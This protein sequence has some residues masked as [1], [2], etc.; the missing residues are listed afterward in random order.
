MEI[1]KLPWTK[2]QNPDYT[3][4][5]VKVQVCHDRLGRLFTHLEAVTDE[6]RS[7]LLSMDSGGMRQVTTALI[8]EATRRAALTAVLKS[9]SS[10]TGVLDP[11]DLL[12]EARS[13]LL[14]VIDS[15]TPEAIREAISEVTEG[16]KTS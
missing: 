2:G 1:P 9:M 14:R 4:A 12:F 7:I 10:G 5:E 13:Y 8:V 11:D 16:D 3:M 6:D 15:I